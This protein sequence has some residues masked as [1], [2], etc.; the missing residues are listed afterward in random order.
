MRGEVGAARGLG[1]APRPAGHGQD[2][3]L[4]KARGMKA[5]MADQRRV[6]SNFKRTVSA[7]HAEG[8]R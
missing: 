5:E 8:F 6:R 4:M 2:R 1:A 3:L 7:L